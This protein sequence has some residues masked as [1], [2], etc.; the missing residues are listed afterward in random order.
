METQSRRA[1]F[2]ILA[3]AAFLALLLVPGS[4]E[5]CCTNLFCSYCISSSNAC[6]HRCA[7]TSNCVV[8]W[9]PVC[10][11]FGCNCNNTGPTCQC[12]TLSR[13][14]CVS[15][16]CC[17]S[18]AAADAQARF[19]LVDANSDGSISAAE[20]EQ[21][22][23]KTFGADWT[24]N[25]DKDDIVAGNTAQTLQTIFDRVDTDRSKSISPAEFDNTLGSAKK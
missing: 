1:S 22:L 23:V 20:T 12:G 10:N 6:T 5:A 7:A 18:S 16:D 17:G 25:V 2:S 15:V 24:N 3:V 8:T 4:A 13:G 21:W 14:A 9:N 11:T 19:K